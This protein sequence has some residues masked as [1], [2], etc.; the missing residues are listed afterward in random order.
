MSYWAHLEDRT[1]EPWC[2]YGRVDW[3]PEYQG[4]EQC[5]SPCY[6]AVQVEHRTDGG[7]YRVGGTDEAEL[8]ITYNYARNW[9]PVWQRIG[10][11]EDGEGDGSLGKMI[12]EKRAGDTIEWLSK[13]VEILGTERDPDYWAA[14]DG[15]AGYA[16]SIL[17]GWARQHPDAVWRIS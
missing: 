10:G 16:L 17:L 4:D 7:T 15:N 1:T 2:S 5:S 8:N 12:G 6:P 9:W 14:T 3:T 13:A 11:P